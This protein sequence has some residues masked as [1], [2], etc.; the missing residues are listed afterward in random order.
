LDGKERTGGVQRDFL[1][2]PGNRS[3]SSFYEPECICVE[4][5]KRQE[6][7]LL[8]TTRWTILRR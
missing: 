5:E 4:P 6:I 3:V 8:P 7:P 2:I 1:L